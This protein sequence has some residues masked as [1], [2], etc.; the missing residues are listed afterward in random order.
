M[1][2]TAFAKTFLDDQNPDIFGNA[3]L[4]YF[5]GNHPEDITV[6][7]SI[8][9]NDKIPTDYLFRDFD[10]MPP[11]E[12]RALNLIKGKTLDVGACAGSHS[13]Y[14]QKQGF[15]VTAL[16]QSPGAIEIIKKRGVKNAVCSTF[17]DF[18]AEKFDTIL[19]LMNGTGIFEHTAKIDQYLLHLKTLLRPGGQ[20]LIDSTDIHYMFEEEDGSYWVDANRDYYGEVTFE[21]SY[22]GQKSATF[23]WLYLD[24]DTLKRFAEE[25]GFKAELL[26]KGEDFEYLAR[27]V[28]D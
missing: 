27:L 28:L 4:D 15:E 23:D 6:H 8:A 3:L 12:Q 16:D 9:E 20:I 2:K 5:N 21:V 19:L 17:L 22:K 13:A 26:E 25:N 7:S 24:F 10:A 1:D 14:L 11:I 18:N